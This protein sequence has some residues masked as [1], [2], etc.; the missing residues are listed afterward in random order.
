MELETFSNVDNKAY[1][2]TS[3]SWSVVLKTIKKLTNSEP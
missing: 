3:A 1:C 2:M